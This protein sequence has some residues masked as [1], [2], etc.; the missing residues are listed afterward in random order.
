MYRLDNKAFVRGLIAEKDYLQI[1]RIL[2]DLP[3][4]I[5]QLIKFTNERLKV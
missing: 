2:S 4:E 5:H 3:K 1:G